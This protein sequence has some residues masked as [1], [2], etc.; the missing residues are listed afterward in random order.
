METGGLIWWVA[1][2]ALIV[3]ELFTGTFYLLMIAIGMIAGGVAFVLGAMP[4]VQ[5]GAAA[6]IALI[7]VA[8]LRRSRFG[9]WKRRN[10][11]SH[12]TAVNLDIGA[13]LEVDQ[14]RDGHARAM[15]RGAQWDVELAPGE[16]EG[17]RLYRITA[18]DGNRLIVAAKR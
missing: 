5:M 15:Y 14:W 9:N 13:T 2:G 8:V 7:A 17:A 10:D 4:H 16:S 11:A 6:V 18:L 12:D 3:A 1:A